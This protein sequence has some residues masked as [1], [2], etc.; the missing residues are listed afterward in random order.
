M[1]SPEIVGLSQTNDDRGMFGAVSLVC[2]P[3]P[4]PVRAARPLT[5]N[6]VAE[7]RTSLTRIGWRVS[8]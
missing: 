6:A 8:E 5:P 4:R 7:A 2:R 1:L 3:G